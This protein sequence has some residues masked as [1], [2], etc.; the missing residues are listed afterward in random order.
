MEIGPVKIRP[1]EI[2]E[3]ETDGYRTGFNEARR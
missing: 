2:R 1:V 3:E